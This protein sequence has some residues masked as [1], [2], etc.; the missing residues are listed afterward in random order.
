LE[1]RPAEKDEA[2]LS[3]QIGRFGAAAGIQ[4]LLAKTVRNDDVPDGTRVLALEAMKAARLAETP[5]AWT[6]AVAE[7]LGK[8]NDSLLEHALGAASSFTFKKAP[9]D[10]ARALAALARKHRGED[11]AL[12]RALSALPPGMALDE[13]TFKRVRTGLGSDKPFTIRNSASAILARA[14]LTEDQLIAVAE[15]IRAAGP[16]EVPR[17]LPAFENSANERVGATL[18]AS[19]KESRGLAGL[20]S[21]QVRQAFAKYPPRV[22]TDAEKLCATLNEDAGKRREHLDA[23]AAKAKEGD[24]RRGQAI[25]NSARAGCSSCHAIGYLGGNLGPD[26]TRIGQVRTERDLLEAIVYPSASFVRSYE[27]LIV[28]TKAG[29]EYSGV[30][31][32]DGAD[33]LVLGTGP[34]AEARIA[35]S[36]IEDTRPGKTSVMPQGFGEQL[37]PAEL[38][39]LL[40]FLKATR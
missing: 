30:V 26:L 11:E 22:R 35:R 15:S 1:S 6:A 16:S 21:E 28:R 10:L 27:P 3:R 40:A 13:S 9:R 5:A 4:E 7:V 20:Q 23:L 39:D 19:L 24:I 18:A 8:G 37:K 36:E 25:F 29:E 2:E 38:A 12:Y 14:R 32:N 31:R 33:E 17:L 34:G